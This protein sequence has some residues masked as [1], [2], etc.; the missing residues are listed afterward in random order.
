MPSQDPKF[1]VAAAEEA[2]T[3]V[4]AAVLSHDQASKMLKRREFHIVVLGPMKWRDASH[5]GYF[6]RPRVMAEHS[7]G[8][9]TAWK[10]PYGKIALSKAYQLWDDR[11]DGGTDIL[12]HLLYKDDT[13]FWGGVKRSGIVVACS[14]VQP[15][16]D[17]MIAS[18]VADACIGL[19]YDHWERSSDKT[20]D[21]LCFLR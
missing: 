9:P 20:D 17:R 14:G 11:N 21:E 7:Q 4:V 10:Y 5:E 8:E 18:M 2:L 3:L 16:F 13:P 19:A 1:L 12:P 6:L 15:H